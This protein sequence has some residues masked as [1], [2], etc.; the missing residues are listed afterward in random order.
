MFFKAE[1]LDSISQVADFLDIPDQ[2]P[3]PLGGDGT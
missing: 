2:F 3:S 1:E